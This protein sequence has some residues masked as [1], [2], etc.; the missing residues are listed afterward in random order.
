[1]LWRTRV[2]WYNIGRGGD[3]LGISNTV[4]SIAIA[5][6]LTSF[7]DSFLSR[8][9][10]PLTTLRAALVLGFNAAPEKSSRWIQRFNVANNLIGQS[11]LSFSE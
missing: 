6:S 5:K 10:F 2:E 3:T 9:N 8:Q 1:V 7:L 11:L 4:R